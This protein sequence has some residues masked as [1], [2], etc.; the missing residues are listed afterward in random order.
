[1][2][3]IVDLKLHRSL[4]DCILGIGTV[5]L[6]TKDKSDPTFEFV[7]VRGPRHLYDAVKK[8]SLDADRKQGVIHIE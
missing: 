4:V 7:K 3:R 1:M 6:V 2:F 8:A 5:T